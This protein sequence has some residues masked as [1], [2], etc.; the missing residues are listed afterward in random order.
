MNKIKSFVLVAVCSF[1]LNSCNS[2]KQLTKSLPTLPLP[3]TPTTFPRYTSSPTHFP[4]AESTP[5]DLPDEGFVRMNLDAKS[6]EYRLPDTPVNPPGDV[7]REVVY[8]GGQGGT[9]G[10]TWPECTAGKSGVYLLPDASYLEGEWKEYITFY[11]CGWEPKEN[12]SYVVKD[13]TGEAISNETYSANSEGGVSIYYKIDIN[14][15]PGIYTIEISGNSG[16]V[17]TQFKIMAPAIPRLYQ[18]ADRLLLY[19]FKPEERIRLLVYKP[20]PETMPNNPGGIILWD[21]KEYSVDQKGQLIISYPETY[22]YD[23]VNFGIIGVISGEVQYFKSSFGIYIESNI[24]SP[25]SMTVRFPTNQDRDQFESFWKI[26]QYKDLSAPGS[27]TYSVSIDPSDSLLWSFSWCAK[28]EDT[29][30][31]ILAPL[32]LKF[33]ID[34]SL[35]Y[36]PQIRVE[37][38]SISNGWVCRQWI[39]LLSEWEVDTSHI[40]EI[41]YTLKE[42]IFDGSNNYPAGV[43]HQIIKVEPGQ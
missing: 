39:T 15:I 9:G 11:F 7:L 22:P 8:S 14:A 40:L 26:L 5:T 1:L 10:F 28:N 33:F 42:P 2:D 16:S 38:S 30:R 6:I 23:S 29:L 13:Q 25:F 4:T 43:Y 36:Y 21:V 34:E 27:Q 19:N 3:S 41:N 18:E 35:V 32:D 37:S 24:L 20:A 12:V 17:Q 31:K